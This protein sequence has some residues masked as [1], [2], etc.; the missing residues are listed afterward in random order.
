MRNTF[1]FLPFTDTSPIRAPSSPYSRPLHDVSLS[2]SRSTVKVFQV[3]ELHGGIDHLATGEGKGS[4]NL[5]VLPLGVDTRLGIGFID[6]F[7]TRGS[8]SIPAYPGTEGAR[9]LGTG[10]EGIEDA[11]HGGVFHEGNSHGVYCAGLDDLHEGEVMLAMGDEGIEGVGAR[12]YGRGPGL[13]VVSPMTAS[14]G[15]L[16]PLLQKSEKRNRK[17]YDTIIARALTALRQVFYRS[18]K[19]A[20]IGG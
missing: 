17:P 16:G 19:E 10:N 7:G 13:D 8:G 9:P 15:C 11:A 2:L 6:A 18:K 1:R 4:G 20:G 14:H 3:Y 12:G 5:R